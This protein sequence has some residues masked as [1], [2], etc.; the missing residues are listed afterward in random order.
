[1]GLFSHQKIWRNVSTGKMNLD[2]NLAVCITKQNN[3]SENEMRRKWGDF[4]SVWGMEKYLLN[5]NT[6]EDIKQNNSQSKHM[7]I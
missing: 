5:V 1:M 7:K 4:L 3:K 2:R 6:D